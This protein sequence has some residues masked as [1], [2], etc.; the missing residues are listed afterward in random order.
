MQ[1]THQRNI[2]I[3][4]LISSL[5]V[6]AIACLPTPNAVEAKPT[7]VT[8]FICEINGN[9]SNE[10]YNVANARFMGNGAWEISYRDDS[11]NSVYLQK[12]GE[13]CRVEEFPIPKE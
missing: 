1:T 8:N 4:F 11:P 7:S 2:L 5:I 9:W 12:P 10:H 6:I 13:D 3:T